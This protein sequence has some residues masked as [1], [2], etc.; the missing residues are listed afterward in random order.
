MASLRKKDRSDYFFACY[1][2]A[3]GRRVQRSTKQTNRKKAQAMADLLE[4]AAKLGAQKRLGESQARR[5]MQD[6]YSA[7]NT[8]PLTFATTRDFLNGWAEKL[9]ATTAPRTAAAY[10]QIARDF[11][12]SLGT[13]A[14]LDISQVE[15]SDVAR[16]R[17]GV[18]ARTSPATA[19]KALKY[20]RIALGAAQ[21]D[22]LMQINPAQL[23]IKKRTTVEQQAAK[24]MRRAFTVPELKMILGNASGE[25]RGIILCGL[26]MGQRLKDIARLTWRNVDTENRQ[27]HFVTA[28]T[29]KKMD[30]PIAEPV[31]AYI[32]ELQAPDDPAAP[33]FPKAYKIGIKDTGDSRLSQQF[34]A[35]LAAS[36]MVD[37]RKTKLK[38]EDGKGRSNSRKVNEISFHSLRHTATSMLKSA[39]VV[40]SVAMEIIGHDSAVISK[41]YTH[42]DAQAKRAA[43]ALLPDITKPTSSS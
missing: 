25:W 20:L 17:D 11:I 15:R 31:L 34:H 29:G 7:V 42:V 26:Y 43:I 5:I 41:H 9:K 21:R 28:K 12:T 32:T 19:H 16:F 3:D 13:R 22:G 35:I 40:E 39:G 23:L 38:A 14:D 4:K 27:F 2:T 36:G 8:E 10:A 24:V 6:I 1:Y 33:L 37:E 30:L 18:E